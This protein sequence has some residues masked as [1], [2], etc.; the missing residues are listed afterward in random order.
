M[1]G[2]AFPFPGIVN[3][4]TKTSCGSSG[5]CGCPG[6][7]NPCHLGLPSC[8]S[9]FLPNENESNKGVL[10]FKTCGGFSD[11]RSAFVTGVLIA[12]LLGWDVV[13]PRVNLNGEQTGDSYPERS[14]VHVEFE[15]FYDVHWLSHSLPH[16][17]LHTDVETAGAGDIHWTE[18]SMPLEGQVH[19]VD[20]LLT[21]VQEA[22]RQVRLGCTLL[23]FKLTSAALEE[24]YWRIDAALQPQKQ[25][26]QLLQKVQTKLTSN[27]A[28][29]GQYMA[30]HYP[31]EPDW[32]EH[33]KQWSSNERW[34]CMTND[35]QFQLNNALTIHGIDSSMPIYVCGGD[36]VEGQIQF[37]HLVTKSTLLRKLQNFTA[38]ERELVDYYIA[39]RATYFVGNSISTFSAHLL[40]QR[41]TI[42]HKESKFCNDFHYNGGQI[43]MQEMLFPHK[44]YIQERLKWVFV[45]NSNTPSYYANIQVAVRSA[46]KK[47]TLLPICI[48]HGPK[49][50]LHD[51]LLKQGVRIL[52][53]TPVWFHKLREV[54]RHGLRLSLSKHVSTNYDSLETMQAT[55]LRFDLPILGFTDNFVLYTDTDV[56]FLKDITLSA[57]PYLPD[58]FMV[59]SEFDPTSCSCQDANRNQMPFG[60]AGIM[61]FNIPNMR[62]THAN[63]LEWTFQDKHIKSG[64]NFNWLGPL[65]QGA[66]NSFYN[67]VLSCAT[68]PLFNWKPYWGA[69]S[70]AL[71]LHFHGPKYEDYC[72]YL[73]DGVS[74]EIFTD[75]LKACAEPG[76]SC[77]DWVGVVQQFFEDS[78][79]SVQHEGDSSKT[80]TVGTH[81]PRLLRLVHK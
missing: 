8:D 77:Q 19:D 74:R 64:L 15:R 59:G 29:K 20:F 67:R 24:A 5:C 6:H 58:F 76:S 79:R 44:L 39:S 70:Q 30:I 2:D 55:F 16:I 75:I 22:G 73:K 78:E 33:C 81:S 10:S 48:Y 43:P 53:H 11:Q 62:N 25:L 51:W 41:K 31:N 56:V 54:Q 12:Q 34:N 4:E 52:R 80:L 18:L 71:I 26:S 1:T 21:K 65:D 35:K 72:H 66:Y 23:A 68:Y 63:F 42:C 32:Q 37:Q 49:T 61:L 14:K 9:L 3:T 27:Q 57:F 40:M 50:W 7:C 36:F 13:L 47:T 46:L 45:V 60:N 28:F 17:T 69:N 38:A